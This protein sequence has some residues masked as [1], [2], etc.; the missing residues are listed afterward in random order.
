MAGLS[1][2]LF[3]FASVPYEMRYQ[4]CAIR[5]PFQQKQETA[6]VLPG[7][8]CPLVLRLPLDVAGTA[9]EGKRLVASYFVETLH[10]LRDRGRGRALGPPV[11]LDGSRPRN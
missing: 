4:P 9:R 3:V 2:Q 7:L 8:G 5:L 11:L 1:L 10:K 6:A